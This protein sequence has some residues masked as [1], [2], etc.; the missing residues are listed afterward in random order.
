LKVETLKMLYDVPLVRIR[1]HVY[2]RS[3]P[4]SRMGILK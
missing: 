4:L 1:G 2:F 3:L